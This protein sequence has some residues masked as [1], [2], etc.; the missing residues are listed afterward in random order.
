MSSQPAVRGLSS[1]LLAFAA[2]IGAPALAQDADADSTV[3]LNQAITVTN[4]QGLD[5]G[6]FVA[7]TTVSLFRLNPTT[8]AIT[9]A[10]GDA[11]AVDSTTSVATFTVT[12]TPLARVRLL[13]SEN[14]VFLTRVGGTQRMRVNRFRV[15]GNRTRRLDASGNQVYRVGG[16]LRVGANQVPGVYE[17]TFNVV[18]EYR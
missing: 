12:G 2:A 1:I 14:R 6:R 7:G 4:T 15:D 9:Q 8:G 16:Q 13:N 17:G 5:F 18:V 3:T 11:I 10:R